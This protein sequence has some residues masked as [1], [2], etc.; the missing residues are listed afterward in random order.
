MLDMIKALL[1]EYRFVIAVVICFVLFFLLE[2]EKGHKILY[3]LMLQAKRLAKDAILKSGK[4]QEDWVVE[5][6]LYLLPVS[7]KVFVTE[8]QVREIVR[9]LFQKGKDLLDDGKING[10]WGE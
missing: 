6:A 9:W 1:W 5:K 8:K 2:R 3:N 7:W 4:A 10:S